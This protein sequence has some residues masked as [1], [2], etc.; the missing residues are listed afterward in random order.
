[1]GAESRKGQLSAWL[2]KKKSG[3][4]LIRVRQYN[5]RYFTLDFDARVFFYAHAENNSKVS[6][7][8]P[9]TD[10]LDVRVPDSQ[11]DKSETASVGSRSSRVSL[12]R[13]LSGFGAPK[14]TEQVQNTV[15]VRLRS[16]KNM[17][18]LC[19]SAFEAM[20][21]YEA[22]KAAIGDQRPSE[23]DCGPVAC[24]YD[25]SDD[26]QEQDQTPEG[27]A[28][29]LHYEPP[30]RASD[31]EPA[32]PAQRPPAGP[33]EVPQG[34][35]TSAPLEELPEPPARPARG[36]FLDF[37][38]EQVADPGLPAEQEQ[39]RLDEATVVEVAGSV[40]LQASDFGF[41]ADDGDVQESESG[42]VSRE[43]SARLTAAAKG[44]L[45]QA[46][47]VAA[48]G[49]HEAPSRGAYGD[50]HAGLSMQERLAN[51]EFSDDEEDDDDP[52]GLKGEA[53]H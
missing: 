22:F 50:R 24:D 10:I 15:T 20:Q 29:P 28:A 18:L 51:L 13:R 14:D 44:P 26:E 23:G 32:E 36:T 39:L 1:M 25:H 38:V 35:S 41:A 49:S 6:W 33:V 17:D 3:S 34:T 40:N 2:Q 47:E 31:H 21:W 42:E 4:S 45:E 16:E 30:A 27:K 19:A 7:I 53:G 43:S 52:L 48:S 5:R 11:L 46:E 8:V 37:E 12:L 9:F